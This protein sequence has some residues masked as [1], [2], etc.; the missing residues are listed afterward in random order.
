[1]PKTCA[2]RYLVKEAERIAQIEQRD[3]HIVI[4]DGKAVI[5]KHLTASCEWLETVH[6]GEKEK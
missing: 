2:P 3:Q 6:P 5:T 1:M 4:C